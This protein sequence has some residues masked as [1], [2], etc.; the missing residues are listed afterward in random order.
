MKRTG[1]RC[2]SIAGRA[3]RI[4]CILYIRGLFLVSQFLIPESNGGTFI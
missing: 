2:V 4:I 1:E 3:H